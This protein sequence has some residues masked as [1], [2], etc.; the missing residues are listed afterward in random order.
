MSSEDKLPRCTVSPHSCLPAV[1]WDERNIFE[2][3]SAGVADGG[4]SADFSGPRLPG[5]ASF[6]NTER[7]F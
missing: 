5:P 6:P 2:E 3:K 7:L 4:V 1:S